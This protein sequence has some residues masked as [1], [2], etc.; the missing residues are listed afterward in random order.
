MKAVLKMMKMM[1]MIAWLR[2][3]RLV[4]NLISQLDQNRLHKELDSYQIYFLP[5]IKQLTH[6]PRWKLHLHD[7]CHFPFQ[8][9]L[10]LY[11]SGVSEKKTKIQKQKKQSFTLKD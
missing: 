2:C 8:S 9:L 1:K 10:S 7:R 5:S 6:V 3:R 11:V 4:S